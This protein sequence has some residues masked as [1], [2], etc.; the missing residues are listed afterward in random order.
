MNM[1]EG[2][3][4][5]EQLGQQFRA[6]NPDAFAPFS[7]EEIG[8]RAILRNPSLMRSVVSSVDPESKPQKKT[9]FLED[10]ATGARKG[11]LSTLKGASGLAERT[12]NSALQ[13]VLPRRAED[14][15]GL[16][17]QPNLGIIGEKTGGGTS[18]QKLQATAE[19]NLGLK[20]GEL[21]TP[22]NFGEK[23]GFTGEQIAEFA[24]PAGA[25]LKLSRAVGQTARALGQAPKVEKALR[26]GS[27]I[28]SE[29]GLAGVQTAAQEGDIDSSTITNAI[30][31][32]SF[33]A[34]GKLAGLASK[35]FR[36][37][38]SEKLPSKLINNLIRPSKNEF[39]FGRNPGKAVVDE[40]IT[41]NTREG[42]LKEINTKRVQ[43]GKETN[44]ALKN[45][46]EGV[47]VDLK[48]LLAPI[49][50]A[51]NEAISSGER[52]LFNRLKDIKEGLTK[53]FIEVEGV[54]T[55]V[56]DKNLILTPE[57]ANKVKQKIGAD[58]KWTGQAFDNDINKV[59]RELYANINTAVDEAVGDIGDTGTRIKQL[60]NRYANLLGAE[61]SLENRI[62]IAARNNLIGL[63]DVNLGV[64]GAVASSATGGTPVDVVRNAVVLPILRK[65]GASTAVRTRVSQLL[66]TLS[67]NEATVLQKIAP[68]LEAIILESQTDNK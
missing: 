21:T 25:P 2:K 15:L 1:P 61:K 43:I 3:I 47:V 13:T 38:L 22:Q 42:L 29:A 66:S 65:V 6:K 28:G 27:L 56:R 49:D 46:P 20:A 67:P 5:I 30:L 14:A 33:P 39:S 32:G 58:T 52:T 55:P 24:I 34:V 64:I 45:V 18:A 40:G 50:K 9:N 8:R 51:M 26:I 59:R 48:P 36:S 54:L 4:T 10:V 62:Q 35:P 12:M 37:F 17:Y 53:E 68:V 63:P 60:N 44:A 11:F 31:A 23:V 16:R 41:A 19:Q 57:N 7:D